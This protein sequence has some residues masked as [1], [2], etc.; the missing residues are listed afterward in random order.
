MAKLRHPFIPV[1]IEMSPFRLMSIEKYFCVA[2]AMLALLLA[3]ISAPAFDSPVT[4]PAK[5]MPAA[6]TIQVAFTPGDDADRLII[7]A[8][9]AA[10]RQ[11]LVQAFSFTHRK[12]GQALVE[13]RRRGVDVQLIADREQ[14]LKTPN[15][16]IAGMIAAGIP[17]WVDGNHESA[18]NKVMVIDAG[19]SQ[20][21]LI[22]GSYNFTYAAQFRNAEN[23]LLIRGNQPLIDA[24]FK[25]WRL[26]REHA[27]AYQPEQA[28]PATPR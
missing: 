4:A 20:A 13:A 14:A 22:T 7:D 23:L 11:I 16:A 2:G 8:V 21:T 6:G 1:R 15:S 12:I 26:H 5:A 18:H 28:A 17:V 27:L 3:P 24:Y 19:N 9:H 25:N 10:R